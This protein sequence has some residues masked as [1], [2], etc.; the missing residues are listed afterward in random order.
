MRGCYSSLNC[1]PPPAYQLHEMTDTWNKGRSRT[2][3]GAGPPPPRV[4]R[5]RSREGE[6]VDWGPCTWYRS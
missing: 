5:E 6:H 2:W 1:I 4:A 3:R